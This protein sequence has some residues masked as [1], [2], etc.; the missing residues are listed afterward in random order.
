MD[1][2]ITAQEPFEPP[3]SKPFAPVTRASPTPT[4]TTS[5]HRLHPLAT[6]N[7]TTTA[8]STNIVPSSWP[9]VAASS[10]PLTPLPDSGPSS[11]LEFELFIYDAD[12]ND[13]SFTYP[14]DVPASPLCIAA[15]T[16]KAQLLT[17]LRAHIPAPATACDAIAPPESV[18]ASASVRRRGN[19]P[20]RRPKLTQVVMYWTFR[21]TILPLGPDD[22]DWHYRNPI[23]KTDLLRRS[24]DEW[25]L[26]REMMAA[27]G[28]ALKCYLSIRH[29]MPVAKKTGYSRW[30]GGSG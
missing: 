25:F 17:L 3:K 18:S 7:I 30:F 16:T 5:P 27:S 14:W 23:T 6:A 29:E 22:A 4:P 20:V 10:S 26:L 21:G 24:E 28:G 2:C 12:N 1:L 19:A 8:S 9:A 11:H 15:N 13:S